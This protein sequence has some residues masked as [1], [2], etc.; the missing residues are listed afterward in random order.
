MILSRKWLISHFFQLLFVYFLKELVWILLL[1]CM[2]SH[3]MQDTWHNKIYCPL[4]QCAMHLFKRLFWGQRSNRAHR[5]SVTALIKNTTAFPIIPTE[6][7]AV[8]TH[9]SHLPGNSSRINNS[10]DR[11]CIEVL[12]LKCQSQRLCSAKTIETTRIV[13]GVTAIATVCLN[14]RT[15]HNLPAALQTVRPNWSE[16]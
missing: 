11:F 6:A 16:A 1:F 13:D 5:C 15:D 2:T 4:K 14:G 10:F 3:Q 7:A 12:F 9:F 8:W